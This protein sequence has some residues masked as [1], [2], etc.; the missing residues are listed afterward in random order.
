LSMRLL[1]AV[2]P[3]LFALLS[4]FLLWKYPLNSKRM[5]EIRAILD[6]RRKTG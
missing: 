2:V 1:F 3:I 5:G 4:L 6:L